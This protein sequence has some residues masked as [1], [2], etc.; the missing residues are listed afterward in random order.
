[1]EELSIRR[2]PYNNLD[3]RPFFPGFAKPDNRSEES[4]EQ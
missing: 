4:L 2:L 3:V 1:M